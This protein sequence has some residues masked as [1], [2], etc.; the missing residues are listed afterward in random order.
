ADTGT[1]LFEKNADKLFAPASMSKI[2]TLEILFKKL[3]SGEISLETEFPVSLYAWKTGGAPSRTTSMFVPLNQTASVGDLIQ[4]IAVQNANDAC[5]AVAEGLAGT[6]DAFGQ[7][8]TEEARAIGLEKST[9]G[10]S[11]GL[12]NPANLVT[13]RELAKL[14]LY[15]I[16]EYPSYYPYFAQ[17][18]FKYRSHNFKNFNPL[19]D[20]SIPADGLKLGFA[21]GA[22]FGIAASA[23]KDG[24]RLVAV[25]NGFGSER[26]RREE[27]LKF[28][29]WGFVNFKAYKV[30]DKDE[31]VGAARVWGGQKW[32]VPLKTKSEVKF[33]LPAA[34]KDLRIKAQIAYLGPLKPPVKEGDKIAEVRITSE[35]AGTSNAAPLYAASSLEAGGV[36]SKGIDSIL[37][38]VNSYVTQAVTKLLKKGQQQVPASTAAPAVSKH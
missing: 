23:V 12:P 5:I 20:A 19:L 24:R 28:L 6:D 31:I 16:N 14:S 27:T 35:S 22:G 25:M 37:L 11:T 18:E 36:V 7:M 1:V 26:E 2:M 34:A 13:A 15:V 4:G 3:K 32:T 10:N 38:G 21:E 8:M 29:S 33:L 17:K 9:F 30:F